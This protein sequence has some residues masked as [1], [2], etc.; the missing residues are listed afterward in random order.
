MTGDLTAA[1]Q[2]LNGSKHNLCEM[3]GDTSRLNFNSFTLT[4]NFSHNANKQ[5]HVFNLINSS[6]LTIA[7]GVNSEGTLKMNIG[8]AKNNVYVFY[9][10]A[11]ST[12]ILEKGVVIEVKY[13]T[14]AKDKVFA[15]NIGEKIFTPNTTD[16]PGLYVQ[17][18]TQQGILRIVVSETTTIFGNA[19]K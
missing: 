15:F 14:N 19:Q 2:N 3:N 12:L 13:P 4:C 17:N 5:W 16:Y 18:D 1:G 8:D 6:T 9:L 10:D 7:S 11:T